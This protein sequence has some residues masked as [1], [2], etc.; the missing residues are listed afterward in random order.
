MH[1]KLNQCTVGLLIF[2]SAL[3]T[4]VISAVC[5]SLLSGILY[6]SVSLKFG[7]VVQM[8]LVMGYE[9]PWRAAVKSV[10]VPSLLPKK[11][12]TFQV[13]ETSST[14]FPKCMCHGAELLSYM[15]RTCRANETRTTGFVTPLLRSISYTINDS[16]VFS[17]FK[18]VWPSL[19]YN[20]STFSV[21]PKATLYTLVVIFHSH[22][23]QSLPPAIGKG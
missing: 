21:T 12:P 17:M 13:V 2:P 16:M 1:L 8:A 9:Q 5:G 20:F 4:E 7:V 18:V 15:K 10:I 19:Q 22:P 3:G 14:W 6:F 23:S 11:S